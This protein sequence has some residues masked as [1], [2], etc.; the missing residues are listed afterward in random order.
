MA[1]QTVGAAPSGTVVH[2]VFGIEL[3]RQS[4][5]ADG[6]EEARVGIVGAFVIVLLIVGV[7]QGQSVGT[8]TVG[9]D[10]ILARLIEVA[11]TIGDAGDIGYDQ[12]VAPIEVAI[13]RTVV[14]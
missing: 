3:I 7:E 4:G 10:K 1:I 6:E 12:T 8:S 13:F 9:V 14:L 2:D 11:T 5:H